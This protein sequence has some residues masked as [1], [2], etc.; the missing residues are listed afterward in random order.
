MSSA[1]YQES[2]YT[3]TYFQKL[4]LYFKNLLFFVTKIDKFYSLQKH[5]LYRRDALM[6]GSD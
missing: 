6:K 1:I 4:T 5:T 2:I 3:H